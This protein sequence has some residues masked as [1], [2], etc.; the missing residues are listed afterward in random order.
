MENRNYRIADLD[1]CI[2]YADNAIA[3]AALLSSFA[4]FQIEESGER[5]EESE[6]SA[7]SPLSS[8]PSPLF[9]LTVDNS[10]KRDKSS[11][12]IRSFDT[13]NGDTVVYRLPDGGYQYVICNL[14]G[15]A[16]CLLEAHRQFTD[17]Y[18]A[19]RGDGNMRHFGLNNAL[20][21]S[22]AF[23]GSY[24]S[25][26]LVHASCIKQ[27]EWGY[28]FTAK[29]G[30][31]KSTHTGLWMQVIEGCELLNDDNPV[32]RI[33][34]GQPYI[35]GSPW[36]GKTPCYRNIRARLGAMTR[37]E[38]SLHNECERLGTAQAF[39]SILP[40]CSSM[41]WDPEVHSNLCDIISRIIETTPCYTMHC[42]PNEEAARVCHQT[43]SR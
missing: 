37:I 32:V 9:R 15:E 8:L 6:V 40:A 23:A 17:C 24:H 38:R 30:T 35:Y 14:R 27:G 41:Q 19:L 16:C 1:I 21:M 12:L 11:T 28:P 13:G 20:M 10:M 34:D 2:S 33:I 7:L 43:I 3:D 29:S 39:A 22:F 42:L 36:S 5:R 26:A 31:G 25:T 18:C 4:P